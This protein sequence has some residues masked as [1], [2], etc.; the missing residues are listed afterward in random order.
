M[1]MHGSVLETSSRSES[2]H[3]APAAIVG[4]AGKP[5]TSPISGEVDQVHSTENNDHQTNMHHIL[6]SLN[7]DFETISTLHSHL[8][9]MRADG[10][11]DCVMNIVDT[12]RSEVSQPLISS[13][14]CLAQCFC[15]FWHAV[16]VT[17]VTPGTVVAAL[18]G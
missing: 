11:L 8:I 9:R 5:A 1:T 18:H 4:R 3:V 16:T 17:T 10:P 7:G 15:L 6:S 14:E 13:A 2:W 12:Q